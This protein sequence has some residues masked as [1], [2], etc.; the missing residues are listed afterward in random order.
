M[1]QKLHYVTLDVFAIEPFKG[2]PLAVVFLPQDNTSSITQDKK[3]L[4][5]REFNFSETIFVHPHDISTPSSRRID[6]FTTLR[7]IPFAGHPTIGASSWFQRHSQDPHDQGV[8]TIVTKSG[9]IPITKSDDGVSVVAQIAHNVRI[10]AARFPL[11]ELL[12]LHSSLEPFLKQK[13]DGFPVVSIV[14]GMSQ[15]HVELPSLEA[16]AAV[17]PS[18]GGEMIRGDSGYLDDGWREGLIVVYFF[19]RNVPDAATGKMVIRTRMFLGSLEDPAT[20]SAASGLAA[21]LSLTDSEV[22]KNGGADFDIVQ[23]VEMGRRSDI[24]VGVALTGDGKAIRSV[25][26]KGAAVK[27]AEGDI[28]VV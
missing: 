5:A 11:S 23:G 2:N 14:N 26:L 24:G 27:V 13:R 19:V 3:Q 9:D 10:H 15:I 28:M 17:Q 4:I 16:L 12:R 7:E 18:A 25:E 8:T 20:G 22:I 1:P 21:Y 6:I